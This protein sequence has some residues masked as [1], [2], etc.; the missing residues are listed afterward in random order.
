MKNFTKC[1]MAIAIMALLCVSCQKEGQYNP[2]KKI[3]SIET[4]ETV[5][6]FENPAGT[7]IIEYVWDG[8]LLT[9]IV[10]KHKN[11]NVVCTLNYAYDGKKRISEVTSTEGYSLKYYY[12]GKFMDAIEVYDE[13]EL[14]CTYKITH[15]DSFLDK[16]E[17]EYVSD[18]YKNSKN[19]NP[20]F[21]MP[22]EI[23]EEIV[24][25]T[26]NAKK[27][28]NVAQTWIFSIDD[29]NISSMSC[30]SSG[31]VDEYTYTY[32]KHR[33]PFCGWDDA[34]NNN[35]DVALSRNNMVSYTRNVYY[36]DNVYTSKV[37]YNYEYKGN[38][39]ISKTW[40]LEHDGFRTEY[41]EVYK[42][43]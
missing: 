10:Y 11:G 1:M 14:A 28:N 26:K 37:D 39:P 16:I 20:F 30:I 15:D 19:V 27:G 13:G 8:K 4:T 21:F 40:E 42:Y 17:L 35:W 25:S 7:G 38:Y 9:Q 12:D 5:N 22:N 32:D 6:G 24:A 2:S 23:G 3:S 36:G 31:V 34:I 41:S 18:D 33:N 43:E 29:R